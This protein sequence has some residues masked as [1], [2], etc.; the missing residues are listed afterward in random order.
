MKRIPQAPWTILAVGL[1]VALTEAGFAQV[2][3]ERRPAGTVVAWGA[4][5]PDQSGP[6]HYGQSTV[7]E[8]LHDVVDI[9]AGS[10]HNLALRRDGTV[11]AWGNDNHGQS[12]VPEGLTDVVAIAAG[13]GATSFAVRRDGTLV[14][15]GLNDYGQATVPDGLFDVAAAGGAFTTRFALRT[16]GTVMFWG[17]QPPYH[18]VDRAAKLTDWIGDLGGVQSL[19]LGTHHAIALLDDGTLAGCYL[20]TI[21]DFGQASVPNLHDV[22]AI[23]AGSYFSLA[24]RA[25][26]SVVAWGSDRYGETSVPWQALSDVVAISAGS[27]HSLALRA[28]GTVVA[29]GY[30]PNTDYGQYTVPDSLT[31]VVAIAA[32]SSHNLAIIVDEPR[33]ELPGPSIEVTLSGDRLTVAWPDWAWDYQ[34]EATENPADADSWSRDTSVEEWMP[35]RFF[36]TTDASDGQRFY[37]LRRP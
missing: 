9:A 6:P 25:D 24:L 2:P 28:D 17:D 21:E 33:P 23:S 29:W 36:I 20:S 4:G 11:V 31:N 26:G 27:R 35:S 32:G 19:D 13:R 10:A 14:A 16:D 30:N 15:W 1:V 8:G 18:A 5:G 37:R 7:P 3:P 34:L 12:R 22:L